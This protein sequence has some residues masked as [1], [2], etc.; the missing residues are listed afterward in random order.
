MLKY[1]DI[2][3]ITKN[4]NLDISDKR[5]IFYCIFKQRNPKNFSLFLIRMQLYRDVLVSDVAVI[6]I[7]ASL[8][9][10]ATAADKMLF[11]K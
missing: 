7:Y 8:R 2:N 10:T 9:Y 3:N 1:I 5:E 4:I 6:R 11:A